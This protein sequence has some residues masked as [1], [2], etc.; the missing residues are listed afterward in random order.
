MVGLVSFA[1]GVA[2]DT[3]RYGAKI[4]PSAGATSR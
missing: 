2:A 3:A 1:L 4:A